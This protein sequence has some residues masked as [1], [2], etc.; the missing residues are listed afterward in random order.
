[1]YLRIFWL[2]LLSIYK[3]FFLLD[4]VIYACLG[5]PWK[6]FLES[7]LTPWPSLS[8][9]QLG[10]FF[11]LLASVDLMDLDLCICTSNTWEE[12]VENGTI[13]ASGIQALRTHVTKLLILPKCNGKI[14]K[15]LTKYWMRYIYKSVL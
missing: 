4:C 5:I 8:F 10:P 11:S 3:I 2:L 15:D 14:W 9:F 1:M 6:K 7:P 12:D 13:V